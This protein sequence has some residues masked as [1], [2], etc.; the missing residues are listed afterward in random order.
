MNRITEIAVIVAG[1]DEE[2]QNSIIEGIVA[3]ARKHDVNVSC[4]AAFG[5]VISNNKYDLGE[6]N[7]Y[8]LINY[9]KL[10]GVIL[11][12]NTISDPVEKEKIIQ[13]VRKSRL[14]SVVLDCDDY[15]EFY[16]VSIDNTNAMRGIVKHVIE[17]HGAKRINYISGPLA[18][19]EATDRYHAFLDV[20][21][22][23]GLP[24]EEE[25]VHFG[26]FRAVDGKLAIQAF[27]KSGLTAPEAIICAND[28]MALAA[29]EELSNYGYSVPGDIIVTGFDNTYNARHHYPALTTVSRPLDEAGFKA[30]EMLVNIIAGKDYDKE[31]RLEASP[32]FTASCGCADSCE[33]DAVIYRRDMYRIINECRRDISLLN[34]MTTG[35]AESET[36]E[37]NL[38]AIIRYIR[39]LNCER[40]CVCLCMN[41]DGSFKD[42][43]H[44]DSADEMTVN[45]YTE[46]MNAPI[47]LSRDGCKSVDIFDTADMNP[48]PYEHG[49]N[50]SYYLPLHYRERCLGYYIFTNTE[51]PIK[52]L[53]CHSIMLNI[54]NSIENIR[55]LLSLNSMIHELDNLYVNDQLC[56][57][58]NRNGFIRAADAIFNQCRETGEKLLISFIDMDGL[59]MINDNYGH[60]EGD[61]ALQRLAAV[62]SDCCRRGW[63]CA[64]F[65]GDE[66]LILG[67]ASGEKDVFALETTFRKQL[68][69]M[70]RVIFK[71]YDLDASIGTIITDVSPDVTLFKLITQADSIMYEKK[72]KKKTSRY[73]RK[74]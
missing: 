14:P 61:F 12:T 54:S 55:K 32:V 11:L 73:L 24:V 69:S 20:M 71:P 31:T 17:V 34:R 62:I 33:D 49:G 38:E 25:R 48:M 42:S 36:V 44:T 7:I 66:F 40:F 58:Y 56:N 57:I 3:C 35:L 51:F 59:K 26:E 64:R 15:P 9:E 43:W 30:C 2:Y 22:E 60:K 65:G 8:N 27:M 19:P 70:N 4:F 1:I 39:E 5:G 21:H 72:K 23:H 50:I 18:N 28:A 29:V 47:I 67:T 52:S 46:K 45:G 13:S 53:I 74:A 16:N 6:Y 68:E 37:D 10:D 41:W 63:I